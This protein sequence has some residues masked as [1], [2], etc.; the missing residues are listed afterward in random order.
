MAYDHGRFVWHELITKDADTAKAFYTEVVGWKVEGMD[1]GDFVYP[2]LKVGEAPVGGIAPPPAEGI[3]PHWVSY[4][5]VADVDAAAKEVVANGGVALMD[6]IDIPTVGR[7]QPVKDPSGAA[8]FLFRS[9]QGDSEP[10]T[11]PGSFHWNE[12]STDDPEAAVAFYEKTF[13]FTHETMEM[14]DGTYFVLKNGDKMRGGI[15]KTPVKGAPARWA[16]YVTVDDCDAAVK[17]AQAHGGAL[18]S[19]VMDVPGVGRFAHVKDTVGAAL[20]VIRPV[21]A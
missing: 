6:A 20:G 4:L 16:Q 15:M 8:F 10:L 3:P 18:L 19:E 12:L 1:M 13:G 21:E 17:R 7:M 5:S 2:M 9:A 11:G 14:P